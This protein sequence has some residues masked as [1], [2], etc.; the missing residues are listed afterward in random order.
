MSNNSLNIIRKARRVD[1]PQILQLT[2]EFLSET[3]FGAF[4]FDYDRALASMLP[5][6]DRPI[7]ECVFL[8][9]ENSAG[10]VA[11][12]I[13]GEIKEHHFAP[14]RIAQEHIFCGK[15]SMR[16]IRFFEEWARWA[17][18]DVVALGTMITQEEQRLQSIYKKKGWVTIESNLIKEL[19]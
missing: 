17:K 1:V 12:V 7:E 19:N 2:E 16:L 6:F 10:R 4:G 8:V 3:P 5:F 9:S 15:D 18:A 11:G 13:G 14:I